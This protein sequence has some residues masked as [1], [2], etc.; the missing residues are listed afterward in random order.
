MRRWNGWGDASFHLPLPAAGQDFLKARLGAA[1]PL[2]EATLE[3]VCAEVPESRIPERPGVHT[4]PETRV[5]HARGQSL[6]DWLAMR[7]GDFGLF[8]DAVA[9][10]EH[11]EEV[12]E[13]LQ[14]ARERDLVVIPYGGGTSVA[15]HINPEDS[16]RPILTLS[17][18]RMNRLMDLDAE[19]QIATFG[20]GTPGPLV[21]SQLLAHGY[22]LGHFPQSFELSTIGGWVASRS[23]GQQSLRYGRIEQLFAG[24]RMETFQGAWEVPTFPASAAGPDPRE[25]VLGSEGR[26]GAI[27]EVKVRVTAVAEHESFHVLF[28]PD[29]ERAR[30]CARQLVQNRTPLSM[31]RLSNAVETETQLALA[32]HPTMIGM[33][34][35]YLGW[36][37]AA[38]GK[39]MMTVGL[40]GTKAQCRT[41]LRELKRI[42]RG[43]D[44]VYTGTYLGRKWEQK[45][46][47]MPYLR[48]T[49]WEQGY[50]VDTLETATDWDNV[51]TLMERIETTL[52]HGLQSEGE[53]VHVFTHLSHVYGQGCSIYTTYVFRCAGSYEA[54]HERWARL[55]QA[56]SQVI[57]NNRGTISHQ[58]GVGK[59]HAPYLPTEKG[60]VT[61]GMLHAMSR[62]MDPDQR[63]AP[64]V[65]LQH[66]PE[67]QA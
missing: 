45:R 24:G 67:E 13:L 49:L 11:S 9:L 33:L 56:A 64:G 36:R 32:G 19:S 60:P 12:A 47:T 43:N 57:V 38:E 25:M 61:I 30:L 41:G 22:T 48:E 59:D 37:G 44:G 42:S 8:S 34:E 2:S 4:D 7:S 16:G 39:C 6:A 10:P 23:S 58:H 20:A 3:Q 52:R 21:E 63:L 40:T 35:R 26:F 17:L 31:L 66:E 65:L 62:Y 1:S 27:T 18:E 50:A 46:F 51:D 29:W 14:W 5:R 54:T 28:F 15:G 55:K 53:P